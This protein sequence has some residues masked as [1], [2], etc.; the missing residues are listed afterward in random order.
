MMVAET[1]E[2]HMSHSAAAVSSTATATATTPL[3]FKTISIY[4]VH[5][6]GM[7]CQRNCGTT[8]TNALL[9]AIPNCV[10]V[11]T[12]FI[13]QRAMLI[14]QQEP[15]VVVEEEE[16]ETKKEMII[17]SL[18]VETIEN[19]GFDAEIIPNLIEYLTE[20]HQRRSIHQSSRNEADEEE[21]K[22][23][24]LVVKE[25][26]ASSLPP[27][28]SSQN[29]LRFIVQGMSCTICTGR[30]ERA[31]RNAFPSS[32]TTNYKEESIQIKSILI[33]LS[34]GSVIVEFQR[35]FRTNDD[36]D[37][38]EKQATILTIITAVTGAG[39]ECNYPQLPPPPSREYKSSDH[40]RI[41]VPSKSSILSS[42][43]FST[44]LSPTMS[45]AE[46]MNSHIRAEWM[47]W[48]RLLLYS[49]GMT[50]PLMYLNHLYQK[51]QEYYMNT[52]FDTNV[53]DTVI[54]DDESIVLQLFM[55]LILQCVLATIVQFYIGYRFY[56]ASYYSII[57]NMY[58]MDFLI[59]LGTTASYVY[60][61]FILL[62]FTCH[63]IYMPTST[64]PGTAGAMLTNTAAAVITVEF[65]PMFTTGAT[66]ITFVTLG[67]FLESYAKGKTASSIQTLLSLQPVIAD[68]VM[69]EDSTN[70]K[71]N[72]NDIH[73]LQSSVVEEV[74]INN[75]MVGDVLRVLP[76]AR[77]P[78]DGIIIAISGTMGNTTMHPISTSGKSENK[79]TIREGVTAKIDPA[80]MD[81]LQQGKIPSS[82]SQ[83]QAYIDESALTGEPFPVVKAI[84]DIVTGSTI[85]QLSVLFIQVTA[86]GQ[87][88]TLSKIVRLIERAQQ[89]KAP[90]QAYADRIACIFAPTV[91][92][93][94]A[95]TFVLWIVCNQNVTFEQ[96][97]FFAFTSAISV[98]VVACPCAL[99]LATP[100]AVMV[101][102][103]VGANHGLLI[104]G[105]AVLENIHSI[106]TIIF[107]KTFTITTG[108]AILGT[109]ASGSIMKENYSVTDPIFQNLPTMVNQDNFALWIA[110]CA[111]YQSEHPLGKSIVNAARKIWGNDIMR[112]NS[113]DQV[114]VD[115]FQ[116][117]PGK[118]VECTISK[119]HWGTYTVRV[120]SRSW[121]KGALSSTT[122]QDFGVDDDDEIVDTIG[123]KNAYDLR[124]RGQIA[125]YVSIHS[126]DATTKSDALSSC[127]N[128]INRRKVVGVFGI[129]DPIRKESKS[130]IAALRNMKI[131]VWLCTGDHDVT[132]HAVAQQVGID[133]RNVCANVTPEGK[134]DLVSRLQKRGDGIF[135]ND[136]DSESSMQ[137]LTQ[138]R[139]R[140]DRKST[141]RTG[142]VAMVGDGINDAVALARA[143]VGIA[144]GAGT[145][146]AVEAADVVLIR[147]SLHDVVVALHLS[148]V[149]FRRIMM[150]FFWAMGYNVFAL[151]FA[152]GVL[153]PF[154]SFRLP[155]EMAGLMMAYSSVSVVTSSLLLRRYQRPSIEDDGSLVGG[156]GCLAM[157]ENIVDCGLRWF[158]C[159][160]RA[161]YEAVTVNPGMEIV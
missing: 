26:P 156:G 18:I 75:V 153:Y 158:S 23:K 7:M 74:N 52:N 120:G 103:G 102:T 127:N 79:N 45:P 154:T 130:T 17:E 65:N 122:T 76:G 58:G 89:N 14:L 149:V 150:N 77:I 105:G 60:S 13:E 140:R 124:I 34:G 83:Q 37:D 92:C 2:D 69:V 101:G 84:G 137:Q 139:R 108:R 22:E 136:D 99:G 85:N 31:I 142:R 30:V 43:S 12:Y 133:P 59:C 131:D 111:E 134:A 110:A 61:I 53:E 40:R 98:L 24:K 126:N 63:H 132:A 39:Y 25:Q 100:T 97:F 88:T 144:I 29:E 48:L 78:T 152:A 107:D 157:I 143:D 32:P 114:Q 20:F 146:V 94:S 80:P 71:S 113:V 123:D 147:S 96:R 86:T 46:E 73:I 91:L 38:A 82:P 66:L 47:S 36:D 125:V 62:L 81:G 10:H 121:A 50:V 109:D 68:K 116:I 148:K 8:V 119:Q 42:S 155:P 115:N 15:S 104:K 44:T 87:N 118:G 135:L 70:T 57:E 19:I 28:S 56:V 141:K 54:H 112:S 1:E 128:N 67:K 49:I 33:L 95:I 4:H 161:R 159:C 5:V 51:K 138:P 72:K 145:E 151:P 106:R 129:V 27:P 16:E 6:I 35:S 90:I 55:L 64:T 11:E 160:N 93:L 21:T 3:S 9:Q 117:I 41:N